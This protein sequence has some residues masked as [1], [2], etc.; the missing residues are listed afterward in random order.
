[1]NDRRGQTTLDPAFAGSAEQPVPGR[2][3]PIVLIGQ[4]INAFGDAF[5]NV[6]MPLLVLSL[7]GSAAQMGVVLGSPSRSN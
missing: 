2:A 3:F 7:T 4:T 1:M 5:A 6:A